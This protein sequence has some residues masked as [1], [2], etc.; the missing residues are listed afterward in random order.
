MNDS[1]GSFKGD[2]Q[3]PASGVLGELLGH[4]K[5]SLIA[6]LLLALIVSGLYPALVWGVAQALFHNKANGSLIGK[7]G[8]PVSEDKDA[9]GSALLGQSF[10][11]AKYFHPRPS[12]AGSG[13]D[14]T[15]SQGS[16]LGPTSAKLILGTTKDF[17]YTVFAADKSHQAVGPVSRRVQGVV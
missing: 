9:V 15:A 2:R 3:K 13:Y 7:D 10:S 16:N 5:V 8:Q 4:V 14:P 12:A 17:A 6:T 11:D 1:N